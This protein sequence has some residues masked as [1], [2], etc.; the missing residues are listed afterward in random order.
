MTCFFPARE[1]TAQYGNSVFLLVKAPHS[2]TA[3][4]HWLQ[5]SENLFHKFPRWMT[6]TTEDK[7]DKMNIYVLKIEKNKHIDSKSP[8]GAANKIK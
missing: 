1:E 4:A 5:Q 3:H 6:T 7:Y 8:N 2:L